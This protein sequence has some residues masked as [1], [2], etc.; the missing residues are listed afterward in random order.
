MLEEDFANDATSEIDSKYIFR[1]RK[2]KAKLRLKKGESSEGGIQDTPN[3]VIKSIVHNRGKPELEFLIDWKRRVNGVK[4]EP[5]WLSGLII[6]SLAPEL[7]CD[8]LLMHVK[9]PENSKPENTL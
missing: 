9:F 4:P 6:K 2:R 7:L 5:S 1:N 3:L 8:F